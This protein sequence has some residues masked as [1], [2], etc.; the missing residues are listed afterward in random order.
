MEQ[1]KD[2]LTGRRSTIKEVAKAAGVSFKTVARVAN[3]ESAVSPETR[4]IVLKAMKALNYSPNISARQLRSKR[5][6]LVALAVGT[7][8]NAAAAAMYLANALPG[9]TRRCNELGYHLLMEEVAPG[10]EMRAVTRLEHLH[11]DGVI[12]LPP[13]SLDEV[14]VSAIRAKRLRHVLVSS[15]RHDGTAPV[16]QIDET[17][18]AY[19]MTGFLVQLGHRKIGFISGGKRYASERRYAGY[20]DALRVAGIERRRDLEIAG[21]FTFRSGEVAA[22]K[23]FEIEDPPTAIF[24]GNDEAALGVMLAAARAG[25]KVPDQLSIAGF[26]DAPSA[27][28]IWPQLT[29]VRQPLAAM[30]AKAVDLLADDAAYKVSGVITLDFEIIE[31]GSTGRAPQN[32]RKS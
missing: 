16:V 19:D 1:M 25:V 32:K 13:L 4:D 3:N 26:D 11:V 15:N 2:K 10:G 6:F 21:S 12:V 17:R 9:V 5:S 24:A 30:T 27:S 8:D 23:L 7:P 29:T 22:Q 28:V 31:R 14:F 18:A 20:I